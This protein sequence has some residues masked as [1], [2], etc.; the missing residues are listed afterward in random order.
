[1]KQ[2]RSLVLYFTHATKQ[3]WINFSKIPSDLVGL[4]FGC[5]YSGLMY[6]YAPHGSFFS[7][8]PTDNYHDGLAVMDTTIMIAPFWG[9]FF[10]SLNNI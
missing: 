6:K 10:G 1:M 8:I 7:S 9:Y 3:I 5:S 4:I 2:L